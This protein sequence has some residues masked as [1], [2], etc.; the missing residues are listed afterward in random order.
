VTLDLSQEQAD[1]TGDP[2]EGLNYVLEKEK[3]IRNRAEL[4]KELE[5]TSTQVGRGRKG[6]KSVQKD[7]EKSTFTSVVTTPIDEVDETDPQRAPYHK[8]AK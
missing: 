6:R 2:L 4:L 7:L 1:A 3:E 5:G 8:Y